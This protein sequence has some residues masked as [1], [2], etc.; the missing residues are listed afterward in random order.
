[1]ILQ[2]PV[3][4]FHY[5]SLPEVLTQTGDR[6]AKLDTLITI[7]CRSPWLYL[8]FIYGLTPSGRENKALTNY[9]HQFADEIIQSRREALVRI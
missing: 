4:F 6:C 2:V 1:M 8:D 7:T 5:S 9:V 3:T